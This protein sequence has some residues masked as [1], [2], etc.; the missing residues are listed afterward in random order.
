MQQLWH[1]RAPRR[2]LRQPNSGASTVRLEL[3]T[4]EDRTLLAA[5]VIGTGTG[6]TGQYFS[7]QVLGHLQL[8]RTDPTVNFAWGWQQSPV[9]GVPGIHFSVRWTGQVQAEFSETYTFTTMSDDG[10]RLIVNG[11]TLVNDW[12]N[13]ATRPDS[14]TLAL[15]AGQKYSIEIDYFQNYGYATAQLWWASPSTAKHI[16]PTSQLYAV[17]P[18][19]A[20]L[21]AANVTSAGATTYSFSVTYTD[22]QAVNVS[23]LA[24]GNVVVTGPNGFSQ[25]ATLTGVST[26]SNGTPRTATYRIN[27]P[28]GSW[29]GAANGTYTVTLGANQVKDTLGLPVPGGSLG[30]FQVNVPAVDWFSQHL[31][32]SGLVSLVRGLDADRTLSRNDWLAIFTQVE[33]DGTVTATEWTDLHTLL[34]SAGYVG[35]PAYVEDLANK[36]VNGDPANAHYQGQV[37]GNLKA[38]AAAGVLKDLVNKWF[39]GLDLPALGTGLHY[40][41]AAGT[42]LG[43]G[44]SY[45]D[46][47]QGSLG[48]CY[49]L[50]GLA[51]TVFRDPAAISSMFISNGDG[52]WTVRFYDNGVADYAT[53]NSALP[54]TSGGDYAY[55]NFEASLG[56]PANKL[57]VALAEKA[58][59]QLAES[60]WSSYSGAA[61]AYSSIEFG[62]EGTAVEQLTGR[63]ATLQT[64]TGSTAGFNAL[65][66]AFQSGQM[67]GLDS[68]MTTA[69]GIIADHVY[70]MLGYNAATGLFTLYNPWGYGQQLTWSQVSANFGYWSGTS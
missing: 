32:D 28:G 40:V 49:F 48:D 1:R 35:T 21:A 29:S 58:Y 19:Y 63:T 52:T 68:N 24:T 9:A 15:K 57:W 62:W 44:P 54:A 8:T 51:E 31:Q 47:V 34:T 36:V 10:V 26:S 23:S 20:S 59:A 37:L 66:G 61:N 39:L 27:A 42:L 33:K 12:T 64:V 7:D 38:G 25:T 46:I 16:V 70:V 56:N 14:G 6:L 55:A 3:E 22:S 65:V 13:H 41:S 45:T 5:P 69:A 18:P 53:V 4:L 11:H 67:V 2:G 30:S 50:A 43:S 17:A 60:G